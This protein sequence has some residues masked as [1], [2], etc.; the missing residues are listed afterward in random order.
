MQPQY[1]VSLALAFFVSFIFLL[2]LLSGANTT[3]YA[4][5]PSS[6]GTSG[7]CEHGVCALGR[8]ACD[9]GYEGARC[10]RR[11]CVLLAAI[12]PCMN[13]GTCVAGACACPA[14]WAGDWCEAPAC[15]LG[16]S[17]HGSCAEAACRHG[18]EGAHCE[19]VAALCPASCSG[20]GVCTERGLCACDEGFG[21]P[22]C[23][24]AIPNACIGNCGG[25]GRCAEHGVPYVKEPVLKRA[26]DLLDIMVG[27][28]SMRKYPSAYEHAPDIVEAEAH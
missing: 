5:L 4:A 23:A 1:P 17:G 7:A 3:P 6:C 25:H 16:R 21:G 12:H 10:E 27:K 20:H 22:T 19:R 13:N 9:A 2:I 18:F 15:A 8:C 24:R 14:G 26:L 28:K 11:T